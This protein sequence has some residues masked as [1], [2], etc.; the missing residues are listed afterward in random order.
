M[1]QSLISNVIVVPC[2]IKCVSSQQFYQRLSFTCVT[3]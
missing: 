2:D 3:I 1:V